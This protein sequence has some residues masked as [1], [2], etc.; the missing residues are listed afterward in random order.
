M[1]SVDGLGFP[2]GPVDELLKQSHG[3]DVRDVMVQNS[4]SVGPVQTG[5]S[6]VVFTSVCPVDAVINKVKCQ[7]IRPCDLILNDDLTV[8]AVHANAANMRHVTPV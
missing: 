2:V 3:E 7:T 6:D 8:S 4:V 1:S 5:E